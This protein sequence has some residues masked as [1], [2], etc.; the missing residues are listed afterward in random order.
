MLSG[1]RSV[2]SDDDWLRPMLS[3]FGA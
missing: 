2:A 1:W 3:S